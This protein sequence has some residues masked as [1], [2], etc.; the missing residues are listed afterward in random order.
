M[1]FGFSAA[2]DVDPM[3]ILEI[4]DRYVREKFGTERRLFQLGHLNQD[5]LSPL[6]SIY[7]PGPAWPNEEIADRYYGRSWFVQDFE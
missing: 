5:R 3:G 2:L 4:D 6:W 1:F 7:T